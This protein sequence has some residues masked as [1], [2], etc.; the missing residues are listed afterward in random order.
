MAPNPITASKASGDA[1]FGI[2][3][4][5]VAPVAAPLGLLAAPGLV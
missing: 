2:L 1:V 4:A 3:L 5:V